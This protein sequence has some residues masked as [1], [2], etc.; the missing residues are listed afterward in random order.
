[1]RNYIRHS[2]SFFNFLQ[3]SKFH[4]NKDFRTLVNFSTCPII[5]WEI[6][7]IPLYFRWARKQTF[8]LVFPDNLKAQRE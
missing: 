2:L 5:S 1:M 6:P 3:T 7:E 8:S 4:F